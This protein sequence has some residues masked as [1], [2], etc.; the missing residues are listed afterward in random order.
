M[1]G[2]TVPPLTPSA[3]N[4][5]RLY[6]PAQMYALGERGAKANAQASDHGSSGF[7]VHNARHA[8]HLPRTLTLRPCEYHFPRCKS[9]QTPAGCWRAAAS[10]RSAAG[11]GETASGTSEP[12]ECGVRAAA[13]MAGT[14]TPEGRDGV[15]GAPPSA[16]RARARRNEGAREIGRSK[17]RRAFLRTFVRVVSRGAGKTKKQE[18]IMC[19]DP[20]L[21]PTGLLRCR[22]A[23][24]SHA[25]ARANPPPHSRLHGMLRGQ[26]KA[27][28]TSRPPPG[29]HTT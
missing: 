20:A 7:I 14:A 6:L 27:F 26:D 25:S 15:D 19:R 2:A 29:D 21:P 11:D 10:K 12:S 1:A 5:W 4:P 17:G 23:A 9:K 8:C 3:S 22:S 16:A 18:Y 28:S 13:A 24:T